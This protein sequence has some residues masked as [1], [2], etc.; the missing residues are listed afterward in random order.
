MQSI[1]N[2]QVIIQLD[3]Q[4]ITSPLLLE[5]SYILMRQQPGY[6]IHLFHGVDLNYTSVLVFK[7]I[8]RPMLAQ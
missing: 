4:G 1:S 7:H 8:F 3:M 5:I 2:I 6:N